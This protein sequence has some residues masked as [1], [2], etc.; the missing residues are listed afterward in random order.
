MLGRVFQKPWIDF[1][2]MREASYANDTSSNANGIVAVA[3]DV[4]WCAPHDRERLG[5]VLIAMK[6]GQLARIDPET[7]AITCAN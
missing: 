7:L 6:N 4:N 5:P 2:A 3:P 1:K